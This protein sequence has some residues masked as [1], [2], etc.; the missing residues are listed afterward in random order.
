MGLQ[1]RSGLGADSGGYSAQDDQAK[2]LQ[3]ASNNVKRAGYVHV[4]PDLQTGRSS[5]PVIRP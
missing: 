1:G 4:R 5:C 2:Y 3:E